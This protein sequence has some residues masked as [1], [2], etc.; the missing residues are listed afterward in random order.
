[1]QGLGY[2]L[3]DTEM[4]DVELAQYITNLATAIKPIGYALLAIFAVLELV[5]LSERMGN[6]NGFAGTGLV[7]EVLIKVILCKVVV[8]NSVEICQF[9][10]NITDEASRLIADENAELITYEMVSSYVDDI[11]PWYT[12]LDIVGRTALFLIIATFCILSIVCMGIV[13]VV[14]IARVIE[15]YAYLTIS[16]IPL[17]TC[18]SK[19]LNV[20]P[21]F[22]KNLLAVGLQGTLLILMVRIF[23]ILVVSELGK[24]I[25][26]TPATGI[27][28]FI[29][30][31]GNSSSFLQCLQLLVTTAF[32]SILMLVCA[33]QTQK[34]AKSICHAM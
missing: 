17:S 34:W 13:Y 28:S 12:G 1:M 20:A 22:I 15:I 32:M 33:F 26:R 18:L 11:F 29:I 25:N 10:L 30:T 7:I 27:F 4:V 9:I 21:N 3:A 31:S 6:I 2:G 8:D 16:P 14:F 19:S 24:I 23:N 5:Q